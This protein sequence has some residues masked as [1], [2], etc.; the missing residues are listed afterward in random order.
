MKKITLLTVLAFLLIN[1][2]VI[3]GQ[4]AYV[5]NDNGNGNAT[6]SVVDLGTQTTIETISIGTSPEAIAISSDESKLYLSNPAEG[7]ISILETATNSIVETIDIGIT[8]SIYGIDLSPDDQLL[9]VLLFQTSELIIV[10]LNDLTISDPIST[11]TG[12]AYITASP[13]GEKVYFSNHYAESIGVLETEN[14]T[15]E[16]TIA[17]PDDSPLEMEISPDNSKVY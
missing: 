5:P 11:G 17:I 16:A 12:P 7:T 8:H 13:D 9:Y 14:N 6:L 10:D 4:T 15:V 1:S 3:H 2:M